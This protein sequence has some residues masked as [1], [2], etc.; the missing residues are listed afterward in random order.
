MHMVENY[1]SP[2]IE[3]VNSDDIIC[4]SE[5]SNGGSGTGGTGGLPSE[6]S[7]TSF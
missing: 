3:V 4:T 5:L 6:T 7:L 2:N 1:E